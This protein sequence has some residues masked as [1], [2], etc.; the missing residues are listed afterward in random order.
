MQRRCPVKYKHPLRGAWGGGGFAFKNSWNNGFFAISFLVLSTT[1]CK[2][3]TILI[4]G[5][6][7]AKCTAKPLCCA[8]KLFFLCGVLARGPL[9][10]AG[11]RRPEP[12]PWRRQATSMHG[13]AKPM[14]VLQISLPC[15]QARA[16]GV[17]GVGCL[18]D[19]HFVRAKPTWFPNVP[20]LKA[21]TLV[22]LPGAVCFREAAWWC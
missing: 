22:Q 2:F 1:S 19:D 9:I 10:R 7:E 13:G 20:L 12:L 16:A 14:P 8:N 17:V 11:L 15:V 21:S 5:L 18:G 3:Y 6:S 4:F